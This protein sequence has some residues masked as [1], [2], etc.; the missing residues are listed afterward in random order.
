MAA[1]KTLFTTGLTSNLI[2][3]TTASRLD[4]LGDLRR[5]NGKVYKYVSYDEGTAAADGVA[6]EIAYYKITFDVTTS[7]S[8]EIYDVTSDLSD[9]AYVG[10]GMLMAAL[11]DGYYGWIQVKGPATLTLALTAGGDGASLTPRGSADGTLD[12]VDPGTSPFGAICAYALD[13]SSKYVLLDCPY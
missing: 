8:E 6:G 7:R 1:D 2:S 13:I 4:G 11:T 9:S 3:T 10:A 5:E 12:V